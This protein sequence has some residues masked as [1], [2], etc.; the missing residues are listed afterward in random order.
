MQFSYDVQQKD[1]Q[2]YDWWKWDDFSR[3]SI[4]L[5]RILLVQIQLKS[6]GKA[7]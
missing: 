6:E 3:G 4:A 5:L 2:E 1:L 7:I